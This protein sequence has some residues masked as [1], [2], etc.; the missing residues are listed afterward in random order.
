MP[1]RPTTRRAAE[2]PGQV[3]IIGGQWRRRTIRFP[4]DQHIRPTPDRVRETLFNWLDPD[5]LGANC[6]DV[7]PGSG[8]LG[9]EAASR[10]AAAVTMND[11]NP[12]I[13]A[14]LRAEC[15]RLSADA[16]TMTVFL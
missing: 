5:I 6:L 8:A 13:C 10:G 4:G 16:V 12:V 1:R 9:I 14:H 2:A 15:E 11:I 3:R 7:F